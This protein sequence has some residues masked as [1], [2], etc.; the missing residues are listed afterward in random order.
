[1]NQC[2]YPKRKRI[3]GYSHDLEALIFPRRVFPFPLFHLSVFIRTPG[4]INPDK[5][6]PEISEFLFFFSSF[7]SESFIFPP[8][9]EFR[10]ESA[11]SFFRWLCSKQLL[12]FHHAS[13]N[14]K[15]VASVCSRPLRPVGSDRRRNP[16]RQ[17]RR[18]AHL[19]RTALPS[20]PGSMT[21]VRR[22]IATVAPFV[23]GNNI[24]VF[25]FVRCDSVRSTTGG[26]FPQTPLP[27]TNRLFT[28][29]RAVLR[30][31]F[32]RPCALL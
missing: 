29:I 24:C 16:L 17:G 28:Y 25:F 32:R 30:N 13:A 26:C 22:Y 20:S 7:F 18:R 11:D 10:R 12:I 14:I 8:L 15:S 23:L 21:A 1:M 5:G 27:A 6:T 19:L 31:L 2:S 4:L 9:S 3:S